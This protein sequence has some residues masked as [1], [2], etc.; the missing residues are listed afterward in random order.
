MTRNRTESSVNLAATKRYQEKTAR[1]EETVEIEERKKLKVARPGGTPGDASGRGGGKGKRGGARG[2]G[3]GE[4][5]VQDRQTSERKAK[6]KMWS[7]RNY[8]ENKCHIQQE[9]RLFLC[10]SSTK[11]GN[12]FTQ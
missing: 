6:V 11:K 10:L 12:L 4:R 7:V 5:E 8:L 9:P 3:T 1:N 2:N